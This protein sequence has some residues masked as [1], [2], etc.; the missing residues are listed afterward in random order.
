MSG[1]FSI[2]LQIQYLQIC[3]TENEFHMVKY[4]DNKRFYIPRNKSKITRFHDTSV[5]TIFKMVAMVAIYTNTFI[6]STG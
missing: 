5:E 2:N 4:T 6:V 1:I 3:D